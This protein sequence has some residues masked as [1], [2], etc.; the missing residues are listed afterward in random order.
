MTLKRHISD[1][2]HT[3]IF[4]GFFIVSFAVF[5]IWV[6]PE[7]GILKAF[8]APDEV[9]ITIPAL[10]ALTLFLSMTQA[11]N[12]SLLFT[13]ASCL[14]SY[15][16]VFGIYVLAKSPFIIAAECIAVIVFIMVSLFR[17]N[18]VK[19][20]DICERIFWVIDKMLVAMFAI[21]PLNL[22]LSFI[23]GICR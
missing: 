16:M 13:F 18:A 3:I 23:I 21:I 5:L 10:F 14:L 12:I 2:A 9:R 17:E 6:Y 7:I 8:I 15:G 20:K 22:P 4:A 11:G 19:K 1:L